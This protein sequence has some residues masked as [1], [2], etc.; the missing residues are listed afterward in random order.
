[1]KR[2][3]NRYASSLA[4]TMTLGMS[5]FEVQAAPV[6]W[7]AN[8]HQ[9]EVIL[10]P[11]TTWA[12]A[13]A[14]AQSLG[15]GWDLATITSMEEQL[16][17]ASLLGPANGSLT[18]YYI[19]GQ[20]VNNSWTWVTGEA[21][22]FTYWGYGEPNGNFYEP[23]LALDAR[24]NVP[25]WGWNDYTGEGANFVAGYI[26]EGPAAVIEGPSAPAAVPEP[27]SLA[28]LSLGLIGLG[29]QL[30]KRRNRA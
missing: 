27:S 19:G 2:N 9:Y 30:R 20:Y 6:T 14:Q 5:A 18:E 25:N 28:A 4:L 11:S 3:M 29:W 23:R 16:F 24:Y 26:I 21:F 12:D 7:S 15:A 13:R 1:M 8:G 22:S 17:I 10:A